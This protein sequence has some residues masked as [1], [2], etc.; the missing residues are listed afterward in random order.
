MAYTLNDIF[1]LLGALSVPQSDN[2]REFANQIVCY[3]KNCWPELK[4]V[5]V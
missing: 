3:L 1:T 2:G 4:I 5:N